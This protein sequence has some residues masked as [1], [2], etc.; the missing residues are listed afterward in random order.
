MLTRTTV[1]FVGCAIALNTLARRRIRL[2]PH[3]CYDVRVTRAWV[4]VWVSH[5]RGTDEDLTMDRIAEEA[6]TRD[7]SQSKETANNNIDSY[8]ATTRP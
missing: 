7:T 3:R 8:R 2:S 4:Y 5:A 6:K 1:P